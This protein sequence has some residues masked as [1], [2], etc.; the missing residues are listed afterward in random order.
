MNA[1]KARTPS[2]QT[3]TE[4]PQRNADVAPRRAGCLTTATLE[5]TPATWRRITE[6][7]SDAF[8]DAPALPRPL[9]SAGGLRRRQCGAPDGG[10]VAR[11]REC[12]AFGRGPGPHR[13]G[14]R[15]EER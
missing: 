9:R 6:W 12:R 5:A 7:R 4:K 14:R 10:A 15:Q 3:V 13:P 11:A 1:A 8:D 2:S